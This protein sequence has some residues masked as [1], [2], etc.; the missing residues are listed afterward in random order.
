LQ[1]LQI[2]YICVINPVLMKSTFDI[3]NISVILICLTVVSLSGFYYIKDRIKNK[4]ILQYESFLVE[5][6]R[7]MVPRYNLIKEREKAFG[8]PEME[9]LQDYFMTLDPATGTV[10]EEKLRQAYL[11]T[12]YL[13]S[14]KSGVSVRWQDYPADIG[15]RTRAIMYDPNDSQHKKV[16]AG[17]VTGGL[18]YNNN[19]R[20]DTSSWVPVSNF[21][22]CLAV[23][24]ITYDPG[25]HNIFYAGTGEA[26]TAIQTYRASTGIG[27]GIW[28]STDGGQTWS[29]ILSTANFEFVTKIAVRNEGGNSVIYAG[30]AS[31][32]YCGAQFQSQP[33]DG[34]FRSADQGSSWQQVLPYMVGTGKP[35]AVSD[36]AIT[37]DG[38]TIIVGTLPNTDGQGGATILCSNTGTLHSWTVHDEWKLQIQ[39]EPKYKIPGRVVLATTP[40]DP[41]VVFALIASGFV[42]PS[43]YNF[44]DFYCRHMIRSEDKGATWTRKGTPYDLSLNDTNFATLAWHALDIAVDPNDKNTVY[45]G[46]LDVYKTTDNCASWKRLS[47]W[48]YIM[49]GGGPRYIHA[50]QHAILYKPG[51]SSEILFG[52]DGGVFYTE[53]GDSLQ[54]VFKE[55][56]HNYNTLQFYSGAIMPTPDSNFFIG[57]LQDNGSLRFT[58][59]PL[60][61][62]NLVNPGDGGYAFYDLNEPAVSISSA[63]YND[64]FI[65]TGNVKLQEIGGYW[66]PSGVFINPADYDSRSNTIYANACT[67]SGNY[68]DSILRITNVC[69]TNYSRV[70]IPVNTGT[71]VY[72]SAITVSPYSPAGKATLFLGTQSGRL[73]KIGNAESTPVKTEITGN[74]FPTANISCIAMGGS[75]DT[76]LVTFSNYGVISVWQTF[77]GGETWQNKEGNLPDMPVRWCLFHPDDY[78][79][80]MLATETGV[81]STTNLAASDPVWEPVNDGMPNVRVDMLSLRAADL[82][83]LAASHGRGFF[84]AKWNALSG[85]NSTQPLTLRIYPNPTPGRINISGFTADLKTIFLRVYTQ[86]GKPVFEKRIPVSSVNQSEAI[87]I[88]GYPPGIYYIIINENGKYARTEKFIKL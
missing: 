26:E 36:I 60:T 57:G 86:E 37:E 10:P 19:I 5:K 32:R 14:M 34:L 43:N 67:F 52:S 35:Y 45:I 58:G 29:Q 24:C 23:A 64:W 27:D 50:D 55:R 8:Q 83:V 85:M 22:P 61:I 71:Q 80:A 4:A 88:S 7:K 11:Q 42:N 81:W 56:N 54:P 65:F 82:T 70:Y 38:T 69:S 31:G 49:S 44:K 12:V 62:N 6:Y 9:A 73:F 59:V 74:S 30:V 1:E 40:A 66:D 87:D 76:L 18:W 68:M 16:W 13:Q 63:Q 20:S 78:C 53:S 47:L 41:D 75:E 28:R 51:S 77:T 33:S 39:N 25:N 2:Q 21:R 84:T 46:G 72:F 79:Q 17:C 3:R 15:G 48:A